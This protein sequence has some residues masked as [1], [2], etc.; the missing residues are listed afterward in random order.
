MEDSIR[1][2]RKYFY[3]FI[4]CFRNVAIHI[5]F[6]PMIVFTLLGMIQQLPGWSHTK[7]DLDSF[8]VAQGTFEAD[9]SKNEIILNSHFF[10]LGPLS[11]VY[12]MVEPFVG[13]CSVAMLATLYTG[14]QKLNS[15]DAEVFEGKLFTFL[16][17]L[18]VISWITQFIGHGVYE[19]KY[20]LN[21]TRIY[22]QRE[23]QR[24]FQTLFSFLSHH[25]SQFSK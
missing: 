3:L 9:P 22:L 13:F 16:V 11:L 6:I 19:S 14:A 20:S 12:L 21:F 17:T 8:S 25:F 7:I 18:H 23:P 24:Q 5:I 4:S 10:L 1:I 2:K 15:M